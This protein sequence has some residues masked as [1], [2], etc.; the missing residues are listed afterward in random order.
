MERITRLASILIQLQTKPVV[1]AQEI[2]DQ[3]QI[4]LRTVYRD[5][6]V[7]EEAGIPIYSEAGV[8]YSLVNGYKLPP[9]SFTQEEA[10]AFV[11]A[12]KIIAQHD[13]LTTTQDFQSGLNKIKAVLNFEKKGFTDSISSYIYVEENSFEREPIP[14]KISNIILESIHK[15]KVL[16]ITYF[17]DYNRTTSQR[18]IEPVGLF[19]NGT[20][21]Y[22][23]AFCLSRMD[24]RTFKLDRIKKIKITTTDFSTT[25]PTI[26]TYLQKI[27]K[28][29]AEL[30]TIII[31]VNP[32][33]YRYLGQQKYYFGFMKMEEVNGLFRMHFLC[34]SIEGFTRW[35]MMF[36]D[37]I[38][39]I[40]P[41][42]LKDK[43]LDHLE[44]IKQHFL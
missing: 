12:E 14:D 29:K 44:K 19:L 3:H 34:G 9:I 41:I 32:S 6:R 27:K 7:L 25:H 39:I 15:S 11:T 24:Y 38:T 20:K 1:K 2:A 23:I 31:D 36:A 22:V 33:I 5:I 28:E 43:L 13:N 10:T 35:L 26:S 30:H 16:D 37:H 42:A 18:F 4:S 17:A 21:W 40:E 8:G